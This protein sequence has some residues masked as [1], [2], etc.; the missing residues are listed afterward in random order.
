MV[1]LVVMVPSLTWCLPEHLE[2]R[3]A[4]A[5]PSSR[6]GTISPAPQ[7]DPRVLPKEDDRTRLPQYR[8]SM[9]RR[10]WAFDIAVAMVFGLF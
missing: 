5:V 3:E 2:G 1:V 10:S 9:R 4:A 7:H 8:Q 6:A